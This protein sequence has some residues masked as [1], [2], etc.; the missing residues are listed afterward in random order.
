MHMYTCMYP[1]FCFLAERKLPV[2]SNKREELFF[3]LDL[4]M[5]T[6]AI[7]LLLKLILVDLAQEVMVCGKPLGLPLSHDRHIPIQGFPP[8]W[9]TPWD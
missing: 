7:P 5:Q 2:S 3:F 1:T 4:F 8:A 9:E 6:I